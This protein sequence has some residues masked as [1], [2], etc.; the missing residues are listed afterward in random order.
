MD[1]LGDMLAETAIGPHTN[2]NHHLRRALVALECLPVDDFKRPLIGSTWIWPFI[3]P[4]K[5]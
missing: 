4:G 3:L 5:E 1:G 2:L